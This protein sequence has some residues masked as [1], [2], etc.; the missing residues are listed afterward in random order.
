M[1]YVEEGGRGGVCRGRGEGW[2]I[3]RKERGVGYVEEG[4]RGGVC[5]RRG[6]GWGM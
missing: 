5:R 4:K 6:E 1:G 2:G 3:Q